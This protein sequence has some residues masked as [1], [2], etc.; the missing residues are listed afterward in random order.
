MLHLCDSKEKWQQKWNSDLPSFPLVIFYAFKNNANEP[1]VV[2]VSAP[3]WVVPHCQHLHL[4]AVSGEAHRLLPTPTPIRVPPSNHWPCPGPLEREK[5]EKLSDTP[6][7]VELNAHLRKHPWWVQHVALILRCFHSWW[8][9]ASDA[10][11]SEHVRPLAWRPSALW[12]CSRLP[13]TTLGCNG[14]QLRNDLYSLCT[15]KG[16]LP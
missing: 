13:S 8:A 11:W 10:C 15:K 16:G 2:A 1:T 6:L 7:K 5:K 4:L 3:V 12:I 9:S 14:P